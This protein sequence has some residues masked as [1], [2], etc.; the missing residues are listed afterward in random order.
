[1]LACEWYAECL[2]WA[3][4]IECQLFTP[5]I[6]QLLNVVIKYFQNELHCILLGYIYQETVNWAQKWAKS[7]QI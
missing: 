5:Y 3:P 7:Q 2:F 4:D 6:A 1:M